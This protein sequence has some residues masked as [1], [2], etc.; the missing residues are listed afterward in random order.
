[1]TVLLASL[2]VLGPV[3]S[4]GAAESLDASFGEGGI[5]LPGPDGLG[6]ESIAQDGAGRLV[7]AFAANG[8]FAVGRYLSDG[9]LDPS[10]GDQGGYTSRDLG[11]YA[12]AYA[13]AVQRG[14]RVI[15][16]GASRPG[17]FLLTRY[18]EEGDGR[19]LTFGEKKGHT[20]TP[21]GPLG[22][23]ARDVEIEADGR[24][25]SAGY[26]VDSRHRWAAMVTAHLPNGSPD[27]SFGADGVVH[28]Q[29]SGRVP[30]ELVSLEALPSGRILL[31]GTYNG[32]VMLM[33]LRA[34]GKPD[35][36]FGGGDGVVFNDVD[37]N[38]DCA[39]AYTADMEVDRRGR[40]V[41][42]A[43][44]TGPR[45]REPA[46]VIR[47]HPGGKLDRSFAHN[48][49]RRAVLGSRLA[50]RDVAIQ[51]NGR[52]VLAGVYNVASSGQARVAVARFLS[53]GKS[54]RSFARRGF[55][56]RELGVE[57]VAYAALVQRDGRVVVGGR[58]TREPPPFPA[59]SVY[60]T[61]EVFLI[62]FCPTAEPC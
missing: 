31:A 37:A 25:L 61:A 39:C 34:N 60:E 52:I 23:G 54:D 36:R 28:F 16:V 53:S 45:Y 12:R 19:D 5:S 29:A 38:R 13:V 59:A 40:I 32:Q 22:G 17:S 26:E 20:A 58:V 15:A 3:G 62:R 43:N 56:T 10:F 44:I 18:A 2:S 1:M 47:F 55:F 4:A 57:G 14:G 41:V 42:A 6:V 27:R 51:H 24:I 30:I 46:A 50:G 7:T 21:A 9:T 49:V 11:H 33:R 8:T 48:G 35:R